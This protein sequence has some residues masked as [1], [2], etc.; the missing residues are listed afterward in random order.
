[1]LCCQSITEEIKERAE[2][3]V[4]EGI[5][6]ERF[7]NDA[8][9]IAVAVVHNMNV[10]VSWN[11]EHIIRLKT[12]LGIEGINRPLGYQSIEIMTPEEVL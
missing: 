4:A 12:K 11:L 5:I 9:H 7:K 6:P 2:R 10:I 8:R 3:Y 1:M